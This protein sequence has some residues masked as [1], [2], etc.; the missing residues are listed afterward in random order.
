MGN[1]QTLVVGS[2]VGGLTMALLLARAG[3]NVTL[4]EKQR[5]IGGY[6]RRFI[7]KGMYFDTGFHFSGGFHDALGQM[8]EILH[9]DD[10]VTGSP[11]SNTIVLKKTGHGILLPASCGFD[12]VCDILCGHF[13]NE[14]NGLK[15][16]FSAIRDIWKN[17][18][19]ADL[20]DVSPI[21]FDISRFD[22]TTVREYC[23][24]AGLSAAAETAA[25]SF[26]TCHGS[27]PADAPMSF[28]A[29]VGYSLYDS[30]ARPHDGGDAIIRAF[31]REAARLGIT[32]RTEAELL[33]FG[34]PDSTG[35][36]REAR[37]RDGTAIPVEDVFFTI[38]PRAVSELLPEKARTSQFQR[39]LGRMQETTSFFCVYY[40][41]DE[42]VEIQDGLISC[43][44][45]NDLDTILRGTGGYST[46]Y[47]VERK[48]D[49]SGRSG[50][51]VTA[52]RT[53]PPLTPSASR[54][55]Q[56][57]LHDPAYQEFKKRITEEITRDL[58]EI[59][60]ELTGHLHEVDAGT[61]LTC[62]D[63]DPP[64][65]SA[66][67][68]RCVCGQTRLFGTLPVRNF[69]LAGQSASVPGIMGAMMTSFIVLRLTLG[70]E[71]YRRALKGVC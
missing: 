27:P 20:A 30:L 39:R 19:M 16:L 13:P 69:H 62:L 58:L 6:L 51:T 24:E 46:G 54:D 49:I 60:P 41:V 66:Y 9:I 55:H 18:N 34:D 65:G 35:V 3:K 50:I 26:A 4:V 37:F 11:L 31:R 48:K 1:A 57:R 38:H 29:F 14:K 2:G 53:M 33:P 25:G 70:D 59:R 68:V 21:K 71:I 8:L 28:H 52:F 43:F 56:E 40:T 42:S 5:T 12:G 23:T 67:G 17:R 44:S 36:C 63:Y 61:P 32:I 47:L 45:E 64:T 15:N 7:R 22:T 10:L